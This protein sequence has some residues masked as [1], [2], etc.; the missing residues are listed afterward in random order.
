MHKQEAVLENRRHKIIWDFEIKTDQ[1][2][3]ARRLDL[4]LINK[5][6][7]TCHIVDFAGPTDHSERKKKSKSCTQTFP[8]AEK[9]CGTYKLS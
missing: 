4:V 5:K 9:R 2:T 7:R 3:Q 8:E 1:R 6:K